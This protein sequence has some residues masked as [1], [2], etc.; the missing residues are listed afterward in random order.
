M[1]KVLL[2]LAQ[3]ALINYIFISLLVFWQKK[4]PIKQN[5]ASSNLG[6]SIARTPTQS[7][8][9]TEVKNNNP[10]P[11]DTVNPFSDVA[12]HSQKSDCWMI[13]DG[14]IYNISSYFG[15]HP[16]GD[17][18]LEKYCGSD[19]SLAFSSKDKTP[20]TAHSADA[21]ALLQQYLVQ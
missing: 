8:E 5:F 4:F 7:L 15:S 3:I 12:K 14:H 1:N 6:N 21:R 10:L 18:A 16:G 2:R 9:P 17:A 20:A 11:T 13:I 19:A